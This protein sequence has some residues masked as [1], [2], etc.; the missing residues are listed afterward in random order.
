M[1]C[2]E[3]NDR[4]E[5]LNRVKEASRG[6]LNLYAPWAEPCVQ[7][8][9]VFET[10]A[11][12][13]GGDGNDVVFIKTN[14]E[15][16]AKLMAELDVSSVPTFLLVKSGED[17]LIEVARVEGASPQDLVAEVDKFLKMEKSSLSER[18]KMLTQRDVMLFMKGSPHRA[19]CKFSRAIVE[20][21]DSENV[22]YEHYDIL[23][24]EEMRQGLKQ[25]SKWPTFPQ[26][27]AKG[28]FIGGVN[29]VS[30]LRDNGELK[31]ELGIDEKE[32]LKSRLKDLIN[33]QATVLFMK[34]TPNAP[35]CQFSSRVVKVLREN[36]IEYGHFDILQDD[37]VRQGLKEY[38]NW[39]TYPQLYHKGE[40]VGGWDV[41][42]ELHEMG[43]LKSELK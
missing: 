14:A 43:E 11:R 33:Q 10:L 38:S 23:A 41:I 35:R 24:D 26:L 4:N 28:K 36:E 30:E 32:D 3:T 37:A 25:F 6:V 42:R 19:K 17:R 1:S 34:G 13:R 15:A 12:T 20:I 2:V 27:Y 31:S 21:L 40:L 7:M 39:P 18:I 29:V 9:D 5:V 22:K 16:N 8:N